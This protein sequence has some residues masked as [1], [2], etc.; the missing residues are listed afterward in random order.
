MIKFGIVG[1]GHIGTRHAEHILQNN[2]SVLTAVCDIDE[3]KFVPY[4]ERHKHI[5]YFTDLKEML[6]HTD[7]DVICIC[8]PNYL[9]VSHTLLVLENDKHAIVEKP[10]ALSTKDCTLMIEQ[11]KQYNKLIFAVKQNRY[12]PPVVAIKDL[13]EKGTLGKIY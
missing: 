11:A 4:Q 5:H 2:E 6:H 7:A 3:T 12:N 1:L 13:I 8:T 10:M 9:H